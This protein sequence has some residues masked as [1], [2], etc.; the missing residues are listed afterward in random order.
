MNCSEKAWSREASRFFAAGGESPLTLRPNL[1][2]EKGNVTA[3]AA[4][5]SPRRGIF[6][7]ENLWG[8]VSC[9]IFV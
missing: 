3:A 4:A 1:K 7:N 9:V 8:T 5:C 2:S 6:V